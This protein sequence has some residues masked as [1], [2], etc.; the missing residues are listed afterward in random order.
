MNDSKSNI[1]LYDLLATGIVP[2]SFIRLGIN[3]LST[4]KLAQYRLDDLQLRLERMSSFAEELRKQPIA[5]AT[6]L[7]N[8]QH[9]ELPPQFF[10]NILG[11]QMKYSCCLWQTATDLVGAENDMLELTCERAEIVDG[12]KIL[13]LGCGWGSFSLFAAKRFSSAK[14]TAV[15]NSR[16]QGEFIKRRALALGLKN[17]KVITADINDYQTDECFD[18]VV[19]VEMFEHAKNY[20]RL[21]ANIASWLTYDGKLFV[22]IFAH[23]IHQYHFDSNDRGDW[24]T[25]YFFTGGTMPSDK[26]LFY[27]QKDMCIERHWCLNGRH[28]QKTAEAW[29]Q[30]MQC[31][32]NA[33]MQV[34][35]D[36]YGEKQTK[37][38]W[39]YWRLFF[40]ACAQT[41]GFKSGKEW[42][43]SHYLFNKRRMSP[44]LNG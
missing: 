10:Q 36:V 30:N 28:Y 17:L 24:L 34:I 37:R 23:T 5:I 31:N 3:F 42:I 29:L 38:W 9:Y 33:L 32:K 12:Q 1:L 11:P 13:D 19:S 40:L 20:E 16:L 18:R 25:K 6:D 8:Q 4:Q 7:A 39:I 15:S 27:F 14:I 21:L 26:L 43:V 22:H 2:E 44:S 41:F 35:A